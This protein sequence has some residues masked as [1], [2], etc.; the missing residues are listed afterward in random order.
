LNSE[1]IK[2]AAFDQVSQF[3]HF[4]GPREL[5]FVAKASFLEEYFAILNW[6]AAPQNSNRS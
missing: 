6:F 4:A 5:F 3:D 2:G 1:F